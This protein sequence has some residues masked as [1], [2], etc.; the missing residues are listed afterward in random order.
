MREN[1]STPRRFLL[2]QSVVNIQADDM[3]RI[4]V[5]AKKQKIILSQ[6]AIIITDSC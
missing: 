3:F 4:R 6:I 1:N 5:V 2:D